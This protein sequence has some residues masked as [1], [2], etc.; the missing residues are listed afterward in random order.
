VSESKGSAASDFKEKEV[1][2]VD[3][4]LER[5]IKVLGGELVIL[6]ISTLVT[7][8]SSRSLQLKKGF[9]LVNHLIGWGVLGESAPFCLEF[10]SSFL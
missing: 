9:P 4:H 3:P 7:L 5:T 6:A 1:R 2:Q 8:S 10:R